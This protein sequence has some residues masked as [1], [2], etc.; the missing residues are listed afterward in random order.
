VHISVSVSEQFLGSQVAF[1]T[2]FRVKGATEE[3]EQAILEKV[4][5]GK[6]FQN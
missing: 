3:L 6:D 2:I 5:L 1:E 4:K